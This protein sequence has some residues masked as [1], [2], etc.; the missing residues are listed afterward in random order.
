[1]TEGSISLCACYCQHPSGFSWSSG[2]SPL[3]SSGQCGTHS[4]PP[5]IPWEGAGGLTICQSD[6]C[7]NLMKWI[8]AALSFRAVKFRYNSQSSSGF[9]FAGFLSSQMQLKSNYSF[10]AGEGLFFFLFEGRERGDNIVE[11]GAYTESR[12]HWGSR[13][14][15]R[16][17]KKTVGSMRRGKEKLSSG[18]SQ[19]SPEESIGCGV[20]LHTAVPGTTKEIKTN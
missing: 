3:S 14:V 10:K 17:T 7:F 9:N 6:R 13:L 8:H 15:M 12:K 2:R 16:E 18:S 11:Q 1:M 5:Q 20:P 4:L 19:L